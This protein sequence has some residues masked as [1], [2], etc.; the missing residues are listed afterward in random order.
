MPERGET[1]GVILAGGL[2]RRMGGID[3]AF[4][5]LHGKP[6]IEHARDRLAPQVTACLISA[7]GDVSRHEPFGLPVIADTVPGHAGPLAGILAAMVWSV[8]NRPEATHVLSVAADT[9]FFPENLREA[10]AAEV[11]GNSIAIASSAGKAH[12]V[13]GLWPVG[14]AGELEKWLRP[15]NRKVMDF[16]SSHD[17]RTVEFPRR[18]DG[19]DPFFNINTPDELAHAREAG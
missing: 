8:R 15:G 1:T 18:G 2:S 3:K 9:P 13:F 10:L 11:T 7:N 17:G 19:T 14:L 5:K 12:P 4:L 16:I 6:L